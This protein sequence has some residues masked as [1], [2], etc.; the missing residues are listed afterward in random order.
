MPD[1]I[2]GHVASTHEPIQARAAIA[3]VSRLGSRMGCATVRLKT[4]QNCFPLQTDSLVSL[5]MLRTLALGASS[6]SVTVFVIICT[7]VR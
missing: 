4:C 7:N 6:L 1:A 2:S 5:T 3:L